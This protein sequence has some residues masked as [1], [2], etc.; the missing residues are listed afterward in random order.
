MQ[1]KL[2]GHMPLQTLIANTIE[3]AR[4]K[5]AS[6]KDEKAKKPFPFGKK[7]DKKDEKEEEHEKEKKSSVINFSDPSDIEKLAAAL[8][9]VGDDFL[10]EA[11]KI[12]NGGESHQGGEQLPTGTPLAGRQSYK[13]DHPKG[14][15]VPM[16]TGEQKSSDGGGSQQM[17]ND[18]AKAPGGAAYPAKGVLK[19][20]AEGVLARIEAAKGGKAPPFGKKDEKGEDKDEKKEDKKDED[21]EKKSSQAVAFIAQRLEKAA[22][23][24]QGGITLDTPSGQGP[25]PATDA[26]GGNDA[27]KA[28]ESNSAA[29]NMKKVDGKV[30]Q[31]RMLAEVLTEPAMSKAHDSKVQ[32]NLRNASKGGVKIAAARAALQKIAAD[33]CTCDGKGECRYCKL[34]EATKK[35]GKKEK[36]STGG[37]GGPMSMPSGGG[38]PPTS[39]M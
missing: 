28:I 33:G 13:K 31:K 10:K 2:A 32:D 30:P 20:A 5:L 24:A 3:G 25:K 17:Q 6:E 27:R 37:M 1:N 26:K 14:H 18:A 12:E 7:E 4:T 15:D 34:K 38:L 19:T 21:K 36:Q 8:E 16:R 9:T 39:G 35:V 11:D 23:H 29:T 22:E